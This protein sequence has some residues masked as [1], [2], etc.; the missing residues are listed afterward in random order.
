MY[1]INYYPELAIGIIYN[2][3][4]YKYSLRCSLFSYILNRLWD[5]KIDYV[6]LD[7]RISKILNLSQVCVFVFSIHRDGKSLEF[8]Y[9]PQFIGN[10]F[11]IDSKSMAGRS[12]ISR[13][14]YVSNN[15]PEEK[16]F[17]ILDW[18]MGKG[19]LP[20]Q[21]VVAYPIIFA[22]KVIAV[23]QVTRRGLNLSE[24]GPDFQK[25]SLDK[26]KSVLDDLLEIH[27]VK[28]A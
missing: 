16:S 25:D 20:I 10:I 2:L 13:R 8:I 26:I 19:G 23:L 27:V 4:L 5:K 6:E 3:I 15:V 1:Y 9:P 21:K 14:S 7:R 28:S 17:T 22:D 24:S 18:L 11:P 12:V